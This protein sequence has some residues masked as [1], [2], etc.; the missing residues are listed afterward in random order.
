MSF[1]LTKLAGGLLMPLPVILGLLVLGWLAL[2]LARRRWPGAVLVGLGVVAL[3]LVSVPPLPGKALAELEHRHAVLADPPAADWIVVL[4][5]GSRATPAWPAATRLSRSSLYRLAEGVRLA[6]LLPEARLVTTGGMAGAVEPTADLMATVAR[7][8]GVSPNRI[9]A[10]G[11]TATTAAEARALAAQVSPGETVLLVTSA[12]HMTRALA[13][14]RGQGIE[15]VP[16]PA[17]HR[18]QPDP[19]YRHAGDLL[20]SSERIGFVET[21]FW[22]WLGLAWARLRGE[23]GDEPRRD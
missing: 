2:M 4:G 15:A 13:L 16:A 5:G 6:G 20:P 9:L 17:G 23:V 18:A 7:Q 1:Q 22:E 21:V 3:L 8:W 11:D 10:L 19:H 14:F 12:S